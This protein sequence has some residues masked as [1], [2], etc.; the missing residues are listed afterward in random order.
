MGLGK[1]YSYWEYL[2]LGTV[3]AEEGLGKA[4]SSIVYRPQILA[5]VGAHGYDPYDR[6]GCPS[7]RE[8]EDAEYLMPSWCRQKPCI[9]AATDVQ[10][11]AECVDDESSLRNKDER[12]FCVLRSIKNYQQDFWS[13]RTRVKC[14]KRSWCV[15]PSSPSVNRNPSAAM[16][17]KS[18]SVLESTY[19]SLIFWGEGRRVEI[20]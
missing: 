1:V 3:A 13:R 16:I 8:C 14:L 2:K 11:C 10:V 12:H 6:H 5:A 9:R 19:G 18:D 7:F 17:Q 15:A 4:A 20:F